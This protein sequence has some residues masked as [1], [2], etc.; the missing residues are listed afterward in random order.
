MKIINPFKFNE[1]DIKKIISIIFLLQSI[2]LFI[3]FLNTLDT[4][5]IPILKPLAGFIYLTFIPGYLILRV[6]KINEL[7]SV[8]S[9][10]FATGLSLATL[11]FTAF[12]LNLILPFLGYSKPISFIS[13]FSAISLIIILLIIIT[14]IQKN[15]FKNKKFIHLNSDLLL[16][17][18]ALALIPFLS[19][20]GTYM[21]NFYQSNILLMILICIISIIVMLMSFNRLIPKS[22]YPF[23]IFIIAIALLLQNSLISMYLWGWD[24]HGEY[25]YA[26]TVLKNGFWNWNISNAYNGVLST[27]LLSVYYSIICDIDISWVLKIIYPFVFS[28]LPLG[29]YEIVKN[30]F[31]SRRIAFL[32]AFF[33]TSFF[34][35]FYEMLALARQEIAEIFLVLILLLLLDVKI[36]KTKNAFMLT[37]FSAS[38]VVSHYA[39][40]YIFILILI[41][42]WLILFI[43]DNNRIKG[44]LSKIISNH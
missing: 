15:D 26:S 2:I 38:L 7:N 1:W 32:S 41:A 27:N 24:I 29:V 25:Y 13:L 16:P 10:L 6:L 33:F 35:F 20:M 4:I 22:L 36:M 44:I 40:S 18:A 21:V 5:N 37:I 17:A 34:V 9:F 23:T 43:S 39:T 19:I 8:E 12:I 3:T 31:K 14:I 11:M 42:T 28:L 30:Q